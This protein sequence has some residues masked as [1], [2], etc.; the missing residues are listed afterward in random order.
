M[1]K[2]CRWI[3]FTPTE[4][5]TI[6][7]ALIAIGDI[8]IPITRIGYGSYVDLCSALGCEKTVHFWEPMKE[9]ISYAKEEDYESHLRKLGYKV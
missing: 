7:S 2:E 4:R 9:T 6:G 8:Y 5:Q 3:Q 1:Q